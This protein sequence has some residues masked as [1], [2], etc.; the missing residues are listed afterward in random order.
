MK[1]IEYRNYIIRYDVKPIPIR[2]FDYNYCHIDYDGPGDNR[3]GCAPSVESC[4]KEIDD[5]CEDGVT[6]NG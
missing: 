2:S 1:D 4:K 3:S 5:L 6:D